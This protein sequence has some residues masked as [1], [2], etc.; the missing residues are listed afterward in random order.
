MNH[1]LFLEKIIDIE[2]SGR[3]LVIE[4]YYN[5]FG[6]SPSEISINSKTKN[7]T[8]EVILTFSFPDANI[9]VTLLGAGFNS[10]LFSNY[11]LECKEQLTSEIKIHL[12]E[13]LKNHFRLLV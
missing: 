1:A 11:V 12:K 8:Y 3:I 9:I 5:Y 2:K 7:G 13:Y 10:F 6:K 4:D